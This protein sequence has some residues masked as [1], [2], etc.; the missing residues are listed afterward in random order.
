MEL[1]SNVDNSTLAFANRMGEIS[2]GVLEGHFYN[3][4]TEIH[5]YAGK[6]KGHW[7]D[8]YTRSRKNQS[9]MCKTRKAKINSNSLLISE[10]SKLFGVGLLSTL[11]SRFVKVNA[12]MVQDVFVC[13]WSFCSSKFHVKQHRGWKPFHTHPDVWKPNVFFPLGSLIYR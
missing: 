3:H 12:N 2:W 11:S 8:Y 4:S 7:S 5:W 9:Y 10:M 13:V 6:K 1:N